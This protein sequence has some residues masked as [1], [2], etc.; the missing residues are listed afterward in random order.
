[1]VADR[2]SAPNVVVAELVGVQVPVRR[3]D[4]VAA[5]GRLQSSALAICVQPVIG[6]TFSCPT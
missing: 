4:H 3:L 5:A 6:R 2:V 1:M